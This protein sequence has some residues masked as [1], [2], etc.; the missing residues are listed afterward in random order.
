MSGVMDG[1]RVIE[2]A[3]WAFVPS[4]G[5]VLAD[6]GADVIKVEHPERPDPMRGLNP[7]N[8]ARA[9]IRSRV[10]GGSADPSRVIWEQCN[11]KKRSIGVNIGQPGGYELLMKLVETADVFLTNMLPSARTKLRITPEDLQSVNPRLVY[12]RGSG[13]GAQGPDADEAG[14]DGTAF[15]AR[16]TFAHQV[17]P[18][19]S[20]WPVLASGVA[21]IGDL[22]GSMML[23]GGIA[24]AL[25]QRERTRIAPIVD[26]SLL[27]TAMWQMAPG[28]VSTAMFDMEDVPKPPRTSAS[29]PLTIYYRLKGHRFLKL[30]LHQ[31]DPHYADLCRRLGVP[32][33]ID[34]PRFASHALRRDNSEAFVRLLDEAFGRLTVEEVR[35]RLDG[36]AGAWAVVQTPLEI[37]HD[38]QVLANGYLRRVRSIEKGDFVVVNPPVQFDEQPAPEGEAG[39]DHGEHT[40]QVLAELG[41]DWDTVV[42]HKAAGDVL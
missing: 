30:S 26:V 3:T 21:G 39:P 33:L 6:W 4:A 17:T 8:L 13:F 12:A 41:L 11:R 10:E 7:N 29:N 25:L 16:G 14:F 40:D 20:E 37:Q 24:A 5:A 23:A 19:G 2:V 18:A 34:D 9:N 15:V 36:F 32:E 1:I 38:P 42:A 35:E 27:A 31:S 22:P 28:I